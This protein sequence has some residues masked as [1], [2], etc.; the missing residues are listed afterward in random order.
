M[1]DD[2]VLVALKALH[3]GVAAAWFG[4]KLLIPTDLRQSITAGVD[5]ARRLLPR[6]ERAERLGIATGMGTLLTGLGLAW[7]IGFGVVRTP[8]WVGLGLVVAAIAIGA[9]V[10]RPASIRLRSAVASGDLAVAG[11]NA[12]TLTGVLS[13]EALL[14]SAALV[15]MLL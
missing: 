11:S 15:T 2:S 6:L 13:A 9:I 14:W 1:V 5:A 8:I 4:H 3:I 7:A 10:A 12:R